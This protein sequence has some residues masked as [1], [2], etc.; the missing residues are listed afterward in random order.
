MKWK[1]QTRILLYINT[2]L[3]TVLL[4]LST[5]AQEGVAQPDK[6]SCRK[7]AMRMRLC[8]SVLLLQGDTKRDSGAKKSLFCRPLIWLLGAAWSSGCRQRCI[9]RPRHSAHTACSRRRLP[10]WSRRQ[11]CCAPGSW[12]VEEEAVRKGGK[13]QGGTGWNPSP[14]TKEC[15]KN[16]H[17]L[18]SREQVLFWYYFYE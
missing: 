17:V 1:Y 2:F 18:P 13:V 3:N 8:T 10:C 5:W 9:R 14:N 12:R 6:T 11:A 15:L 7:Q 4:L 16:R